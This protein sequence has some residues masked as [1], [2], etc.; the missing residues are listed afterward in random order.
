[1]LLK[2]DGTR[3]QFSREKSLMES[4]CSAQKRPV[5][6]SDIDEVVNRVEQKRSDQLV[7]LKL[8]VTCW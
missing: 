1:M 3:E 8:K 2:K 5:S 4:F 7:M 6:T